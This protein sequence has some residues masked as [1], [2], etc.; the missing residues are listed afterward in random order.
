MHWSRNVIALK[1]QSKMLQIF[2]LENKAKLK[3]FTM[4]EDVVFWTWISE[5]SLGL[6]TDQAVWHWNVMDSTSA[7]PTKIFDRQPNL[8]VCVVS[9]NYG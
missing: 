6:V 2:D 9:S 7:S 3:S 5:E 4:N 1:A 8:A